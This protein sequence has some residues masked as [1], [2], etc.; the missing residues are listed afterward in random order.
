MK[1]I[2]LIIFGYILR[3]FYE[4][5]V[6]KKPKLVFSVE[7]IKGFNIPSTQPNQPNIYL[8]HQSIHLTNWGKTPATNIIISH[9]ILP[10]YQNVSPHAINKV[11]VDVKNKII[12]IDSI[13]PREVITITYL[14]FS[15][16]SP[17]AISGPITYNEGVAKEIPLMVMPYPNK[18]IVRII[19]LF[20]FLGICYT[21]YFCW[22]QFPKIYQAMQHIVSSQ[23]QN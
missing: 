10:L 19:F 4:K 21:I 14:D 7:P 16:Y 13:A 2:I 8:W 9:N 6:E 15:N 23:K 12:T 17:S 5:F 18:W 20:A 3:F 1:D 22:V 11:H